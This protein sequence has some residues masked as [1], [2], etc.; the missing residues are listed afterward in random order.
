MSPHEVLSGERFILSLNLDSVRSLPA[1]VWMT[2]H[3]QEIASSAVDLKAGSNTADL[4]GRIADSGVALVEGHI[5]SGGAEQIL[6]SQAVTVRRPRVLDVAGGG[7]ASAPLLETLKA[8]QVDVEQA[9]AFPLEASKQDWDAVLLD[10]YPDHELSAAEESALEQYVSKGGGLIFI[11]GDKNAK[12]AREAKTPLQKLLPV[13]AQS[14]KEKPTAVV[15]VLDKSGSMV[16][17]T[18]G[19]VREAARASL[20]TLRPIDR[21]GVISFNQAFNWVI[22]MDTAADIESKAGLID[23]IDADGNTNIYQPLLAAYE[24]ILPEQVSSRHI[25]LLTDGDQTPLTFQDFAGLEEEAARQH[26]VISTIGVGIDVNHKLLDELAQK[27][28]GRSHF[29]DD[30]RLIPQI[31]NDEVRSTD[32]LAIQERAVH[33][34]RVRTMELTDGID[35]TRAPELLGFVQA[36]AKESTETILGVDRDKPLLVRWQYGLGSVIAFMS[37]ARNRWATPWVGWK[38]F[39]TLWPQMVRSVV[40]HD[41]PI[42]AGVRINDEDGEAVVEYDVRVDA[43]NPA[44]SA[45][46]LPATSPLVVETPN[47]AS[48]ELRLVETAPG[49][50]EARVPGRERG[51]YR[52]ASSNSE[53]PLPM[54]GFYRDADELKPEPVNLALLGEI[55]RVTGGRMNPS[56]EQIL[57]DK[58]SLVRQ[59]MALW[60]YFV[61]LALALNF[62]ELAIRRRLL[63]WSAKISSNA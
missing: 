34:S 18:M 38:S 51:L 31:V 62:V 23:E 60:P 28:K 48:R 15:L 63:K 52:V 59:P 42:R 21:V 47:G 49:H 19:I 8:A 50:Y 46:S 11:A 14:P 56:I 54:V 58:D 36:Q 3:G 32:D 41:R 37:D 35:F 57:S 4:D 12:L 53:L 43:P 26:V 13:R 6:F 24:A 10:N 5:S 25:I 61:M 55:S 33:A 7:D 40:R 39:G 27:T 9:S 20:I 2:A 30:P 16:G 1:R 17:R 44:G 29:V 22:P 45:L